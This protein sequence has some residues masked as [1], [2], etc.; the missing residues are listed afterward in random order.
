MSQAENNKC[1]AVAMW[2][3][4]HKHEMIEP[5][6]VFVGFGNSNV[7]KNKIKSKIILDMT[8]LETQENIASH[9]L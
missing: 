1:S 5:T 7:V 8:C 4:K 3:V 9:K 6:F 2:M